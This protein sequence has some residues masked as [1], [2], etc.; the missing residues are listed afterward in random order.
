MFGF[1]S[2]HLFFPAWFTWILY[3]WIYLNY[4]LIYFAP[5]RWH[6]W[7]ERSLWSKNFYSLSKGKNFLTTGIFSSRKIFEKFQF[8]SYMLLAFRVLLSEGYQLLVLTRQCR[9]QARMQK[10]EGNTKGAE[11]I[12]FNSQHLFYAAWLNGLSWP[13]VDVWL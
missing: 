10:D 7:V 4:C 3:V 8:P 5:G 11:M 13:L 2:Q 1:N 12:G 6:L 9:S